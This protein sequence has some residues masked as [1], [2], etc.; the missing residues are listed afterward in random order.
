MY[1]I[2]RNYNLYAPLTVGILGSS[3]RMTKGAHANDNFEVSRYAKKPPS[4][5]WVLLTFY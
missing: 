2:V 1:C 5:K 4:Q 3:P